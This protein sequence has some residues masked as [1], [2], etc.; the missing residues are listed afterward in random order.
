MRPMR[1][2]L[3]LVRLP[4]LFTSAADVIAGFLFANASLDVAGYE[5]SLAFA[6]AASICLYAAG[7]VLND[8]FDAPKDL[9][10]RPNRPIPSGRIPWQRAAAVGIVLLI[11]G[12]LLAYG[13]GRTAGVLATA[14]AVSILL[15]DGLFKSTIIGPL[16]MGLCRG[17]N[18]ALG[19]AAAGYTFDNKAGA[20][21][22]AVAV[23]AWTI[24]TMSLTGFARQ[25]A[26]R[27][28]RPALTAATL[29]MLA[30]ISF[31]GAF[32][33]LQLQLDRTYFVGLGLVAL[34]VLFPAAR[35]IRTLATG[36]VQRAVKTFVLALVLLG[37]SLA[38]ARTGIAGAAIVAALLIPARLIARRIAVT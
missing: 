28:R 8:V 32:P 25:E 14:L 13:A 12:W 2:W 24:Y 16:F 4:N 33:I 30:G 31:L 6:I 18:V 19:F 27:S 23:I 29:G 38:W 9:I 21:V 37:A 35:A 10:E 20:T 22:A 26:G 7:V 5:A 36:D 17:I 3:Q 11:G 15:Y 34:T 1:A